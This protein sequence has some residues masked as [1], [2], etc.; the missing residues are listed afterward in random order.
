MKQPSVRG[1]PPG[2]TLVRCNSHRARDRATALVGRDLQGF[3]SWHTNCTGGFVAIP[4]EHLEQ[5]L[6]IK[7]AVASAIAITTRSAGADAMPYTVWTFPPQHFDSAAAALR[8]ANQHATTTGVFVGVTHSDHPTPSPAM[9]AI[10]LDATA[11]V[12]TETV[13]VNDVIL[14]LDALAEGYEDVLKLAKQQLENFEI[15]DSD[16]NRLVMKL[17]G[18]LSYHKLSVSLAAV[19]YGGVLAIE[20]QE[21]GTWDGSNAHEMNLA[22]AVTER[23]YDLLSN[24]II[25]GF[26]RDE[27][28]SQVEAAVKDVRISIAES[29][30]HAADIKF[31]TLQR[32]ALNSAYQKEHLI[33][34]LLQSV[35]RGELHKIAHEA[36]WPEV[37]NHLNIYAN[38]AATRAADDTQQEES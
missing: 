17:E 36:V 28:K 12:T 30:E 18:H 15:S 3:Y 10:Q 20:A 23:L 9:S 24:R 34:D 22:G 29:A 38:Q 35:F 8:V 4:D 31:Q 11:P 32:D 6:Q 1:L 5:V 13:T 19:I 7:D 37:E 21:D 26:L 27:I 16:W 33:K 14:R 2:H 25:N